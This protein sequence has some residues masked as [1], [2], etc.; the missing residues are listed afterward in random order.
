[1][2]NPLRRSENPK[3]PSPTE[4]TLLGHLQELR[5]RLMK[6]AIAVFIG[7]IAVWV[8]YDPILEFLSSP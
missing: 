3:G 8:F 2:K 6:M 5:S 4:M 7:A 1:M